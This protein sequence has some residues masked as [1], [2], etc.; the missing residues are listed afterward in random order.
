MKIHHSDELGLSA[1]PTKTPW[2]LRFAGSV[3]PKEMAAT[4]GLG[5]IAGI[6]V[7]GLL[8]RTVQGIVSLVSNLLPSPTPKEGVR[9]VPK[10]FRL[11]RHGIRLFAVIALTGIATALT[12]IQTQANP[13]KWLVETITS[14]AAGKT[15][16]AATEALLRANGGITLT[17]ASPRANAIVNGADWLSN[18]WSYKHEIQPTVDGPWETRTASASMGHQQ[19][20][21]TARGTKLYG[22]RMTQAEAVAKLKHKKY[23]TRWV[24]FEIFDDFGIFDDVYASARTDYIN[25]FVNREF[26]K[27]RD[28]Y[29]TNSPPTSSSVHW[30]IG[31]IRLG[32]IWEIGTTTYNVGSYEAV[33]NFQNPSGNTSL[34]KANAED[35]NAD[36][37]T[38]TIYWEY[39]R[40]YPSGNYSPKKQGGHECD[41]TT[42]K[43]KHAIPVDL[44][45]NNQ[46]MIGEPKI[47]A[48]AQRFFEDQFTYTNKMQRVVTGYGYENGVPVTYHEMAL[49]PQVSG[50]K[51]VVSQTES[52]QYEKKN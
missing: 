48:G 9:S 17:S 18:E 3:K 33:S 27:L 4:A 2:F 50:K 20:P 8:A 31:T 16:D 22:G 25:T 42:I 49:V 46:S 40:V 52:D 12:P 39:S 38:G 28:F 34:G 1:K 43:T 51:R 24:K 6:A 7:D 11:N 10:A 32:P 19:E 14:W 23:S 44:L 29:S 26:R 5:A 47:S 36:K 15:L 37:Y 30:P 13:W 35:S 41:F 45:K 21:K